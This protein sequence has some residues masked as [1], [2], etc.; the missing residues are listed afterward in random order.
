MAM[1]F[2]SFGMSDSLFSPTI[3]VSRF[4]GIMDSG[5]AIPL[6]TSAFSELSAITFL[7]TFSSFL[8]SLGSLKKSSPMSVVKRIPNPRIP[9]PKT[10]L[11]AVSERYLDPDTRIGLFSGSSSF[12][13][14]GCCSLLRSLDT[15]ILLIF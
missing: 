7:M 1:V 5:P 6:M 2:E 15:F 3:P 9:I 8:L 14:I 10:A 11:R 13:G 4:A 12:S